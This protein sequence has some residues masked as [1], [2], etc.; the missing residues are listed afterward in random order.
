MK[1]YLKASSVEH[2]LS[3][4]Q[5]HADGFR[6]VAG[7]TD[8]MV[9]KAQGNE[10][11]AIWIDLNGITSLSGLYPTD[12][13]LRIGALM[14][15]N[16]IE[17]HPLIKE[18]FPVLVDAIHSVASP[19]IRRT[20]TLGGNVLCENRCIFYNQSEWW[21]E[22]AGFCLKCDG[23]ICLATGG[24]KNCF[25][26]F[27][28]DAAVALIA[29]HAQVEIL[30]ENGI[31][32]LPLQDLY[33]GDGIAPRQL[34]ITAILTAIDLPLKQGFKA[35]FKKLRK[36]ETLDFTSLTSTVAVDEQDRLRIVL[37]G[38]HAK[39]IVVDGDSSMDKEALISQT[40]SAT[41]VIDNDTYSRTYRRAMISVFLRRSFMEL[42]I[43]S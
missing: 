31:T 43:E 37:G 39:P 25:A 23:D 26:K 16:D 35:V 11:S 17:G 36:R 15:L 1:T 10:Q 42:G 4:A 13:H 3:L 32:M 24:S 28:S 40:M 18:H 20:A 33:S 5:K 19:T 30:D 8:V 29:L 6:Y 2:A 27:V 22:A 12:G 41:R 9:N 21:R 14:T 7:G 34:G 38:V